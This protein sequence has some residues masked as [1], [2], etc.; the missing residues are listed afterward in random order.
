MLINKMYSSC[1]L[2]VQQGISVQQISKSF[3]WDNILFFFLTT[4]MSLEVN[5]IYPVIRV[6]LVFREI[7]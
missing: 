4:L 1:G 2:E 5:V 6:V 3:G 7:S